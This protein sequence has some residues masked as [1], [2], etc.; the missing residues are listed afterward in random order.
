MKKRLLAMVLVGVLALGLMAGCGKKGGSKGGNSAKDVE[1]SYWHAGLGDEWLNVL[2]KAFNEKQSEYKVYFKGTADFEA[3]NAAFGLEDVDTVDLYLAAKEYDTTYLEPLND[4]LDTTVEGES[5]SIKEKFDASYLEQEAL[6]G[7]Y[8]NLT[9][10]GGIMGFVYSKSLFEKAGITQLPRTT[11][12][13]AVVCATLSDNA[14]TPLCHFKG[15][16]YYWYLCDAWF[17]QYNGTEYYYDFYTDPSKE[18]MTTEDGRYKAVQ[19]MEKIIKPEYVLQGSNSDDHVTMQTKFLEGECGMMFTGS[20]LASEMSNSD[21]VDNFVMMK[22]PVISSIIDH[23]KT[24]KTE[25][26]LRKVIAA[27]DNVTDGVEN[28]D[29]YKKGDNYVVEGKKISAADWDTV[30]TA[31]NMM[32]TN[33]AGETAYIPTYSN[34]QEG[35]KEFLK[36]MYSDEGY[37]MYLDTLHVK[38]PMNL[39]TGDID[40]TGWNQFELNQAE[41]FAKTESGINNNIISKHRLFTDGGGHA[42]ANKEFVNLFC[43][44]SEADRI[45]ATEA[46]DS[47]VALINDNYDKNWLLNIK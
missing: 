1:I 8:Y 36:F 7:N 16:Q 26:E 20:W 4:V 10:G 15:S 47:I 41:L 5:V 32:P 31:R 43:S 18:K 45:S 14:I 25:P 13:L 21:K 46:W 44:H 19:A 23:L 2:V 39:S 42:F 30:K 12:E 38:M 34:A 6:D 29:T 35:A 37:Q 11:D 17:A 27:I 33:Y 24:V 22:T 3:A 9:Y 40:T 28:I